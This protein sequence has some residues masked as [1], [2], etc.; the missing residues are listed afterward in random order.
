MTEIDIALFN[1]VNLRMFAGPRRSASDTYQQQSFLATVP[2]TA[3][4]SC[5]GRTADGSLDFQDSAVPDMVGQC[6]FELTRDRC[7]EQSTELGDTCMRGCSIVHSVIMDFGDLI[8][9]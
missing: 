7:S 5:G 8:C 6:L 4:V 3:N 2:A 1:Q 9:E